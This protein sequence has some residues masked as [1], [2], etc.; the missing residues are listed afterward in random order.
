MHYPN[1][2]VGV[3]PR[4]NKPVVGAYLGYKESVLEILIIYYSIR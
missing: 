4:P 2:T 1:I 3:D